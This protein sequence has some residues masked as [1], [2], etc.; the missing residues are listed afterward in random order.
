MT[1]MVIVAIKEVTMIVT[2]ETVCS[3]ELGRG[4][5][6]MWEMEVGEGGVEESGGEVALE[7]ELASR[8]FWRNSAQRS[9]RESQIVLH[10]IYDFAVENFQSLS[11]CCMYFVSNSFWEYLG[12]NQYDVKGF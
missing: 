5:G 2:I 8:S 7:V 6:G 4:V 12:W 9:G 10:E 11:D 1:T 3:S